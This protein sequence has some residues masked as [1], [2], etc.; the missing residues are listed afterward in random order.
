MMHFPATI[1]G[2]RIILD[3]F[4]LSD[5]E[6]VANLANDWELSKWTASIP[7]PYTEKSAKDWI[8]AHR[9]DEKNAVYA[10]RSENVLVGCVN[11]RADTGEIGYWI[12]RKYWNRGF[13]TSALRA[14]ISV[15]PDNV[16]R[17]V[18]AG[19]LP[20]NVASKRVLQKCGFRPDGQVLV[21]LRLRHIGLPLDRFVLPI[22]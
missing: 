6:A 7:Y 21:G 18:W 14:L 8:Y 13:A 17:I 20:G 11:C 12:G 15:M 22:P 1:Q 19:T 9:R 10:I 5:A 16:R 4:D 2:D 3:A